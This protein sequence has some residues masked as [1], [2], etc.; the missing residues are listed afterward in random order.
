[1]ID[2]CTV[3][4]RGLSKLAIHRDNMTAIV[5]TAYE[6]DVDVAKIRADLCRRLG[7]EA[8]VPRK[9]DAD[10]LAEDLHLINVHFSE[11]RELLELYAGVAYESGRAV[12]LKG[13]WPDA[14]N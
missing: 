5:R 14:E 8:C 6:N 4:S 10:C 2:H 12:I 9:P 7:L 3:Y 13:R 1:M 11:C